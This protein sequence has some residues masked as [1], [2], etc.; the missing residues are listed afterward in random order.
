MNQN[1]ETG[2]ASTTTAAATTTRIK[3]D[4]VGEIVKDESSTTTN[5]VSKEQ[6]IP[7]TS[8]TN[9]RNKEHKVDRTTTTDGDDGDDTTID[10]EKKQQ[11]QDHSPPP[12]QSSSP[13]IS[14]NQLKRQQK[15][16]R[17]MEVKRRKKEHERNT[18]I[19]KAKAEGRNI[20]AEQDE[21]E[22]RR[23]DGTGWSKRNEKW[24]TRFAEQSS[25]FQICLDC[26]Y[27]N[28]MTAKE[29]N[30]LSL[31]IR[32]C[33]ATNKKAKHPV[34]VTVTSLSAGETLRLIQRVSGHEQWKQREF[35]CTDKDL[36]DAYP[37]DMKSRM[38]YLTS[39]SD[40]VLQ[41]LDDDAIYIIGGIVDRN[42][43]KRAAIDRAGELGIVTAKLP[44]SEHVKLGS[45]TRVLTCNHV[46]DIL[47]KWRE[48]DYDWKKTLLHVLPDR[49]DAKG[50]IMI[51]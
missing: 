23:Q 27:E 32:Y 4:R 3:Q 2:A 35:Y 12:T 10:A 38:V 43:L 47:V 20:Q 14:K 39:D 18:K 8:V 17:A 30:S 31:Q 28:Q 22:R 5:L 26:S 1:D 11:P 15:W 7:P 6:S 49:K 44:I 37:A 34:R 51:L 9:D 46:F 13:K 40:N 42:R 29:I 41:T 45:A 36:L 48:N 19:A 33:Y 16:E 24:K 21:M 25:K 50:E